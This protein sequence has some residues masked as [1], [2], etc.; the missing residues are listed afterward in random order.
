MKIFS[1]QILSTVACKTL[2]PNIFF[3]N[4]NFKREKKNGKK[5]NINYIAY[6]FRNSN[7]VY[8]RCSNS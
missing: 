5:E 4:S 3:N 1:L 2:G 8:V 7:S 6:I